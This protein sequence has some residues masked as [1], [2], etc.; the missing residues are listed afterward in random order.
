MSRDW[1]NAPDA[2]I[3]AMIDCPPLLAMEAIASTVLSHG[4]CGCEMCAWYGGAS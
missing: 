3:A 4:E 1:T 2:V